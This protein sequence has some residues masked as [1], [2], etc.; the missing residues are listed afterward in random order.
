MY[1]K[2]KKQKYNEK[3]FASNL[4]LRKQYET[5]RKEN[6]AILCGQTKASRIKEFLRTLPRGRRFPDFLLVKEIED[7]GLVIPLS[8]LIAYG[9][10][11]NWLTRQGKPFQSAHTFATVY[12]GVWLEEQRKTA[13][14]EVEETLFDYFGEQ[15]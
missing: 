10:N 1:K 14:Q 5:F 3:A 9:E 7:N 4:F 8:E 11:C 15:V 2:I 12:N 6:K 13:K